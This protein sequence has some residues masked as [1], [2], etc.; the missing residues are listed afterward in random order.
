VPS[1]TRDRWRALSPYLDEA[2][3]M[4]TEARSAWLSALRGRDPALAADLGVLLAEHDAVSASGF[5]ERP[6]PLLERGRH[7]SLAGQVLGA[8]RLISLIGQGGMGS[9]WM[10]ERCDGRFEGRVAVKLLN[11]A[12]IGRAGGERF[13]REGN[14]L[15]RI[16]HPHIAQLIDAGV[17]A[18]GQPYLV[19]EHVDG[20]SI[21]RYCD[22]RTLGIEARLRLFLDVLEAVAHAHANL[23]VHRDIKPANVLVSVDGQVKL[24]DFGIA[25]LADGDAEWG[26]PLV[27]TG[28]LT[29]ENGAALTPHYAAPEQLAHGQVTTATDIYALG[30]LL[31]ELLSGQHPAGDVRSPL[32]LIRAIVDEEPRR[33]SDAV[34]S[35]GEASPTL[36]RHAELCGTTS[37]RLRWRLRGDLDTIVAKALKKNAAERY[38]SVTALADDLRRVLRHQPISARAHTLWY[39]TALFIRRHARRCA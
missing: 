15:A 27:R 31:Y 1:L 32:T 17:S 24:L 12:L 28:T 13:R 22:E 14:I 5:L 18:S 21:D 23:I 16:S 8:Y 36:T 25:R 29:R 33:M 2:L 30:V 4:A 38:A 10:A 6:L 11:V 39:R 34:V 26:A 20:L 37:S 3:E 35:H 19:L 7:Q 9:V